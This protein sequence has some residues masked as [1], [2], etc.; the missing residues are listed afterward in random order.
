[1]RTT[2]EP[3]EGNKVKLCVEVDEGE[4]EAAVAAAVRKIAKEVRIPGFR[5]GKAPRRLLEAR[6]G[7][8]HVRQEAL[9]EAMPGFYARAVAEHDLDAIAA[10]EIEVTAGAEEG[11]VTFDAVVELR[12]QV[13]VPGYQ[14]LQVTIPSP[15][16]SDD[17]VAVQVDR[18]RD[19]FAQLQPVTRPARDRDHVTIDIRGYRHDQT[20]DGLTAEDLLYE[21]G[22]GSVVPELDANLRGAR[23]G[24]ILKFN[25]AHSGE[26]VAVQL[27]VKDVKEKVLPEVTDE[28][29]S[30]ASEFGSVAGLQADLRHR[31]GNIRRMQSLNTLHERVLDALVEL[32]TIDL[33]EALVVTDA[34]ARLADMVRRIQAQG[35]TIEQYLEATGDTT[36]H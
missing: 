22:S 1:M 4:I 36:D 23:T 29:A 26:E 34:N 16:V 30:E 21:V 12:P 24:D 7:R 25:A 35:S 11:P 6:L 33:P 28:W 31:M 5:P 2:V 20:I 19:S 3:L 27:L 18:L 10:P 8:D 14:G 15:H 9:R 17:D 32:V 13:S